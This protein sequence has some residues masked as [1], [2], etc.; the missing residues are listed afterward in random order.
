MIILINLCRESSCDRELEV[1]RQPHTPINIISQF[2]INY[3]FPTIA[4]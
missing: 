1:I 4:K 2:A 3:D